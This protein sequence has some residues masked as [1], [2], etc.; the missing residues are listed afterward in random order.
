MKLL[1][2]TEH[3]E[4]DII[5][6]IDVSSIDFIRIVSGPLGQM[7]VYEEGVDKVMI[8]IGISET[9]RYLI[10]DDEAGVNAHRD[11]SL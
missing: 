2:S 9:G 4:D 11:K 10:C 7:L 1:G 6:R 5:V 3:A 8:G